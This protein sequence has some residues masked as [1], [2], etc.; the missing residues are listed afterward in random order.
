MKRLTLNG[1]WEM[2]ECAKTE[3]LPAAVPG[4][5]YQDLLQAGKMEDPF[6]RDNEDAA[7]RLMD[8]DYEYRRTFGVDAELLSADRVRLVCEGLDT[9]A[10]VRLNGRLAGETNNMHR[11]HEFAVK[12]LLVEGT[13]AIDITFASPNRYAEEKHRE[14]PL[15]GVGEAVPGYPHLRKGHSMFGWDWGPQLPDAG[16]WRSIG[17]I[18]VSGARLDDV[19]VSQ[20]HELGSVKLTVAVSAE[21]VSAAGEGAAAVVTL[22]APDGLRFQTESVLGEPVTEPVQSA[23]G[24]ASEIGVASS[25]ATDLPVVRTA[26]TKL[27]L[28]VTEPKL[29]WPNGYGEQP[30]YGLE[31][32]LIGRDGAM[33][34]AR[35]KNIGLRTLKVRREKD[36]WGESFEFAVNGV[37]VFAQGANYIP[38][39]NLLGRVTPARTEQ[40][41][42]D[43]VEANFNCIRVW[44]GG[45]YPS[46]HFYDLCD[47]LGLLV[48][49]DFMF[50]C[51]VYD[52][53][54]GDFAANIRAEAEDN[55]KRLR[56]HASL[57]LWCGNNEMEWGWVEW[58]FPGTPKL[59]ADYIRQFE[60]LLPE[61][62][63]RYDPD[64]C[65]WPAS[66]SSGGG[67]D[68]PN[69]QNRG[70]VHYWEV[71]HG[72]KPFTEYRKFHFRFCSEFGFQSFPS[73]KTVE[74]Y[75]LPEDRNIFSY[76][77]EK[78]QKNGSANGKILYYI[79]DNF[80]YP[81][82][83]E[84]MIYASQV[85]QA[86]AIK[87]G[88]EHWRRNR[89]RCMGS[90]YW[91]L[92]DCWPVASWSSIDYCGRWKALH[93]FAKRFYAPVLASACEEGTGAA[94]HVTNETL[95]PVSGTMRWALRDNEGKVLREGAEAV[96]I[97]ALSAV[98][99]NELDFA[100][101]LAGNA[102]RRTYLEFALEAGT[103]GQILSEG[104][105]LFTKAKHFE[106]RNPDLQVRV[107]EQA[108]AYLIEVTAGA[109]AKYV[110]LDLRHADARFNDNFF[111]LA[112]G[113]TFVVTAPKRT[114]SKP[115]DLETFSAELCVR[116]IY[117]LA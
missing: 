106:W 64:R 72:L 76:V 83:F 16:I 98:C 47:R 29:W 2:K 91:Q 52:L 82:D 84:S 4:S 78:H 107:E 81:K 97:P 77:M 51:G 11:T 96:E 12:E 33:L 27:S 87:Y 34:D 112:P 10:T 95:N 100:G 38:E 45:L 109:Y 7:L 105:V 44:G 20:Q 115:L 21:V 117:D 73:L 104:T 53:S 37:S 114:L 49:Q 101:E 54:E 19:Y 108:D 70:D 85:L 116:S 22:T 25:A 30:L 57:A 28:T 18:G 68:K 88:V 60:V 67:F 75:T 86:E 35:T 110:C 3:W 79:S 40:L 9:L 56:H 5:V 41:L 15:W 65:Y 31:V 99:V 50:A 90:T 24:F 46:D 17:L 14:N 71:W 26:R 1:G 89:G 80:L 59:K 39:D 93:Y 61:V 74:T 66:P 111:D 42:R 13:N 8:A 102:L 55:V 62:L 36:E 94:L 6:Y 23:Y 103:G 92:N 43:C 32:R 48:W 113:R 69:D 63:R 58:S